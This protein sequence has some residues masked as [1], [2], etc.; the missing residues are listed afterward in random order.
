MKNLYN[1]LF[2][3]ILVELIPSL[4]ID[5]ALCSA[6]ERNDVEEAKKY[7]EKGAKIPETLWK[8]GYAPV[9]RRKIPTYERILENRI[10]YGC[11][12]MLT[13]MLKHG[14]KPISSKANNIEY[15]K[16]LRDAVYENKTE[17]AVTLIEHSPVK[18]Q[19]T[20]E[21]MIIAIHNN[22]PV[23]LKSLIMAEK[24]SAAIYDTPVDFYHSLTVVKAALQSRNEEIIKTVLDSYPLSKEKPSWY[25]LTLKDIHEEYG[26]L[27]NHDE[28]LSKLNI[29]IK[30][31][32]INFYLKKACARW[33]AFNRM[34]EKYNASEIASVGNVICIQPAKPILSPADN[35]IHVNG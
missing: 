32:R 28:K 7:L 6:I 18:E 31:N 11:D 33:D 10:R 26:L 2:G 12:E 16:A 8:R 17:Q 5:S 24:P 21:F 14:M 30:T 22:N 19:K 35:R 3:Q 13:L 34:Q 15:T 1:S 23:V 4:D 9:E 29:E 27:Y 25:H 20:V